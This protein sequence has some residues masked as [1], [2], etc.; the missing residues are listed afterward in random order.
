[1]SPKDFAAL[2]DWV[3]KRPRTTEVYTVDQMIG[4]KNKP[5]IGQVIERFE[6]R[7][8]AAAGEFGSMANAPA[9]T[10]AGL[11]ISQAFVIAAGVVLGSA[12][13]VMYRIRTR[14]NRYVSE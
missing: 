3:S 11:G 4:G 13:V 2:V 9:F 10:I 6:P 12:G 5:V 7:P 8:P 14:G 1:M